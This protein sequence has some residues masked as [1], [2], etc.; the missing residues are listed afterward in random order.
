MHSVQSPVHAG[1]P[2]SPS[3]SGPT[4]TLENV[5]SM[6]PILERFDI[7]IG[8]FTVDI[9]GMAVLSFAATN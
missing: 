1:M 6:S 4:D 2:T 5:L 7:T 9:F 3:P 8:W